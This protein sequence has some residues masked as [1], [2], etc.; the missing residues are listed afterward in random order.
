MGIFLEAPIIIDGLLLSFA[1]FALACFLVWTLPFCSLGILLILLAKPKVSSAFS[2]L[3]I[4]L[5]NFFCLFC[6]MLLQPTSHR[7]DES[8]MGKPKHPS[9]REKMRGVA[10]NVYSRKMLQKPK[11]GLRILKR[12]VRELFTHG[13]VLAPHAPI[14]RDD[15]L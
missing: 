15:C 14:T 4:V 1:I 3:A 6:W 9:P 5:A 2:S 10:T 7:D 12:R 8:K 11:R 13:K